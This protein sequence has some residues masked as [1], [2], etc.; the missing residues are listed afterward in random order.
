[1]QDTALERVRPWLRHLRR[2]ERPSID[3]EKRL[4][5]ALARLWGLRQRDRAKWAAE[6]AVLLA[7]VQRAE[8][9]ARKLQVTVGQHARARFGR[10]SE[11]QPGEGYAAA[12]GRRRGQ[13]PGAQGHGRRRDRYAGVSARLK[14]TQMT[15]ETGTT[16]AGRAGA[17]GGT[18]VPNPTLVDEPGN[19]STWGEG[20][21]RSARRP[22]YP[23]DAAAGHGDPGDRAQL[24]RQPED[25]A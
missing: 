18:S 5:A 22:V 25:G 8:E 1:M 10:R 7:Q 23:S 14:G 13:R 19:A 21:A 17:R 15:D 16:P 11:Q 3:R 12:E 2:A 4:C 20:D 6:R 24:A 9:V